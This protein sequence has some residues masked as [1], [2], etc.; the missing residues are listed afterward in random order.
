MRS[1]RGK[2]AARKP[3][4]DIS[5]GGNP[6][7]SRKKSGPKSSD[8][9]ALDRLLLARSD[10]SNLIGQID[11]LASRAIENKTISKKASQDID[12]F[13]K[14]LSDM[15][16]SLK[17]WFSRLQ[18]SFG[19]GLAASENKF[20]QPSNTNSVSGAIGS[21]DAV[22]SNNDKSELELIV[23][24]SP[25][26]SWR[27]GTC[28]VDCGRQLF[29]LTPLPKSKAC[30]SRHPGSSKYMTEILVDK[31]KSNCH[32]LFPLS[33]SSDN[34]HDDL[35]GGV[36]EKQAPTDVSEAFS[37][38]QPT[39]TLESVCL[40]TPGLSKSSVL[41]DPIFERC[42]QEV[43]ETS[44]LAED[45]ND[46]EVSND[47]NHEVS[48][49]LATKYQGLLGL[50]PASRFSTRRKEVDETLDWFLSP[51]KT[52][53]LLEPSE[54][55]P[56]PT[57]ET[58]ILLEPSE[59]RPLPTPN[60]CVL[61]EPSEEKPVPTPANVRF[62]FATPV[63]KDLESTQKGKLPGEA[64][65]KRELWTKFDAVS[66]NQLYFD[67]SV[68]QRTGKKGFLDMLEE[69]SAKTTKPDSRRT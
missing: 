43:A 65:L 61:L 21:G 59:E 60:T 45:S 12:S 51:P 46:A 37:F 36:E 19:N 28:T 24:P 62:S 64:T 7:L 35:L 16:S 52:C 68:F 26:V 1:H 50:R 31:R 6:L 9:G 40:F 32:Q 53:I 3:L 20:S 8:D 69:V 23:S 39:A 25:L 58:C 48:N 2:S 13:T 14:I 27:A 34:T 56:L 54:E 41:L 17:P 66:S 42:Q 38:K 10:L 44:E 57:P 18:Q 5:N 11:E 22:E 47:P 49:S 33:V 55:K 30:L 63:W 67:A 4:G 15:H 29:L